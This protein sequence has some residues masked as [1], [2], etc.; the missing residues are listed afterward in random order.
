MC[1]VYMYKWRMC[2]GMILIGAMVCN[3]YSFSLLE[4]VKYY[5]RVLSHSKNKSGSGDTPLHCLCRTGKY[6][7]SH[8]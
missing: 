4:L 2:V 8:N 3:D 5:N 1:N 6:V 7:R